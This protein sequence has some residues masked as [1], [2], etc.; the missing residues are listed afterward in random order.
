M[1]NLARLVALVSV[2][3]LVGAAR[4]NN[5]PNTPVVTEPQVGR[6]VNP[7]DAHME[8]APFSDPDPGDTHVCTDWEIWTVTPVERVWAISCI[9]GVERVHV[10][11]GDGAFINSYAGRHDL[12]ANTQYRLR[13]RHRDSSGDPAT[14]WSDWGER[15]FVTGP[16]SQIFPLETDD[17]ADTPAPTWNAA[18]GGV[19]VVLPVAATPPSVRL[20]SPTGELL[21]GF[22]GLDGVS[23]QVTNPGPLA[24]HADVRVHVSAGSLGAPLILP[25]TNLSFSSHEG[26]GYVVYLPAM[27]VPTGPAN[28]RYFWVSS[29]GSTYVGAAGQTT[30]DFGQLAR[31]S[32]VPWAVRQPGFR[33]EVVAT[34]FQLP[35][36]IAFVPNPGS[37]PGSPV[38]YVTELYGAIKVVTRDGTVHDYATGL[39][40][41]NPTGAFPGS[42]EQ[43][44][45]GVVVDPTNGDVFATMLYSSTPGVEAAPH[46]PRVVR[47]TSTDGGLTAATQTTILNMVGEVQGQSHQ[48][49]NITFGPDGRLYVH[50]GDGFDASA[51]QNLATFRGKVLRLNQD[52]TAASN[53]PFY[54]AGDGITA[55]DYVF[56]YGLRNPFGGAWREAD[57][58]HYEA[59]NGPSVDRL[60]K[61][62]SARNYLYDGY[63][64]SMANFAIYNWNPARGPVNIAFVQPGTFG[65]SQF[66]AAKQGHAFVS[67]SGPTWGTGPQALGKRISEFVLDAQ[68]NLVSGPTPLIEYVGGG[69]A[70]VVGLTAGPDGLYFTDLYKDLDYASPID[71]GANV[72]RV[73]FIGD[74]DF[75]ANVT[76][77]AA[78]LAVTF[79]DL[80][81]VPNA[82]AWSWDFGDGAASAQ[83]NPVHTYTDDGLYTVR[84]SVTGPAGLAVRERPGYIRV[85]NI[86]RIAFIGV[87]IP[88]VAPDQAAID[89]LGG[90]G[91]AVTALDDDP[92]NRPTA[93]QI[94][95]SNGLVI[96]SSTVT[97]G[98]IGGEFRTV[99]LPMIFWEN[100]LLRSGRESL[101]DNGVVLA[102]ATAI[103]VVTPSHPIMQGLTPGALAV[104]TAGANMSVAQGN[105]G[106]GTQ[107]LARPLG[108]TSG[109][110]VAA[111]AGATVAAGYVTPARRVFL[112]F[113]DTS[114]TLATPAAQAILDR[115]VCW[116][117]GLTPPSITQQPSNVSVRA[118]QPATFSVQA[119]GSSP[120][121][122]RWRRNG[123]PL[124]GATTRTYTISAVSPSDA[125]TYDAVVTN[126]CSSAQSVAALLTVLPACPCD[127]NNSGGL[128]SQDFFDF[129]TAFFDGNAD[130][131][132]SGAT[133]SQDFFDFLTCF[134][135]GC[136]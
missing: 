43:G 59:E 74:A 133:D 63:D 95:Q 76:S 35:V 97:S 18:V 11:L 57:G 47:F 91:Y 101:T 128:D 121:S 58:F 70:S 104:F 25:D 12:V 30:P 15:L 24:A 115:S 10:H 113:E 116:A 46:Y 132:A 41:F 9:G 7:G 37:S 53:N 88:P 45:A 90:L 52:G 98:N 21:L 55:R 78:P 134:F 86:P 83:R 131:N 96:V 64:T 135:G 123:Q 103:E 72:L 29:S 108:S 56:A 122:F 68:G 44:V 126:P 114:W 65:G 89:H 67:E 3:A 60:A 85:G 26:T 94:A 71:R 50:M 120:L 17:V 39:L 124:A 8:C 111:E 106:P 73:R 81:T 125:G 48:I 79:T 110:I 118:G 93:A 13:V 100:A 38:Y 51:G 22:S 33:V 92:A 2:S 23:N 20:E 80:S 77:G 62:V 14:E 19:A 84:L 75:T 49:S 27:S 107:V 112:F 127:W 105:V 130:F 69:K 16:A 42:G 36:N 82:T 31:G 109:A 136:P 6:I 61:I 34:G 28:D 40:N 117:M 99:N 102:G 119:Q 129:L 32:P 66:P 87:S 4:A 5:P 1:K 54:N